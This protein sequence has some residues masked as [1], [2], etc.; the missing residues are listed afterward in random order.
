MQ[1][2]RDEEGR[3]VFRKQLARW[4]TLRNEASKLVGSLIPTMT[5]PWP[6]GREA[7]DKALVLLLVNKQCYLSIE[8]S[9]P[10]ISFSVGVLGILQGYILL[11]TV[12]SRNQ[13]LLYILKDSWAGHV[14]FLAAELIW[15]VIIP[16]WNPEENKT[17]QCP[18]VLTTLTELPPSPSFQTPHVPRLVLFIQY[19]HDNF[20]LF[21]SFPEKLID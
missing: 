1:R 18:T 14:E 21:S 9:Y 11:E 8:T 13:I 17:G 16:G 20:W 2:Q 3:G 10:Y 4:Q 15:N 7:R 12:F 6:W 19:T 5:P